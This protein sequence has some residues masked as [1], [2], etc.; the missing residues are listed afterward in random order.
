V[1]ISDLLA[2]MAAEHA[3]DLY[4]SHG[5]APCIVVAGKPRA[6]GDKPLTPQDTHAI[7]YALMS[8]RQQKDFEATLEM[9]LGIAP[10]GI[11]RFRVNVY[12]QRGEVALAICAI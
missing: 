11:G 10:A 7:A 6:V 8:D 2:M 1:D 3:S 9:N 12:R 4:L 5:A